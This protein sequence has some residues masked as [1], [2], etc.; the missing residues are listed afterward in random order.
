MFI[1]VGTLTIECGISLRRRANKG[2]Y[3]SDEIISEYCTVLSPEDDT[4]SS[5]SPP[6]SFLRNSLSSPHRLGNNSLPKSGILV[7]PVTNL[8]DPLLPAPP[9]LLRKT[10]R[11][12]AHRPFENRH[13]R[14]FYPGINS[15]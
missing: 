7:H 6:Y 12:N 14:L 5:P 9:P 2:N 11:S 15:P 3:C 10:H 8:L 4:K 1:A 13:P